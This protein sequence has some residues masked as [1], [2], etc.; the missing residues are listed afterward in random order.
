MPVHLH[1][2]QDTIGLDLHNLIQRQDT[3]GL[4]DA[5]SLIPT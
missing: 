2:T 1:I 4:Q 3:I 5:V